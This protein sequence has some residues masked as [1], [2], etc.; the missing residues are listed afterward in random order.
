MPKRA[1]LDQMPEELRK[2]FNALLVSGG[3][4][5]YDAMRD[6]L[7]ERGWD[8]SRSTVHRYGQKLQRKIEA[9][10]ASTQAAIALAEAAPDDPDARSAGVISL[11]QSE[12]FNVLMDLQDAERADHPERLKLVSHAARSIAELTRASVHN[13]KWQAEIAERVA[14]AARKVVDTTRRAGVSQDTID[15]I[16]RDVLRIAQ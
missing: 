1:T 7:A 10:R 3:F 5:D 16:E 8:V 14:A 9:V 15:A 12:I 11:V 2:E 13:K 6:W 4:A